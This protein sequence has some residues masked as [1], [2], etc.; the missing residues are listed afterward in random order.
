MT[1]RHRIMRR[2]RVYGS[3]LFDPTALTRPDEPAALQA[4]LD[5]QDDGG[6]RGLHFL[7]VNTSIKSQF[8]FIQQAWANNPSFGGLTDNPDPLIGDN[9]PLKAPGGMLI[10]GARSTIRTASL[11][12]FVTVRGGAYLFMPGLRTLRYL[13]EPH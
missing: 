4:I 11:P 2:G 9:D 10:P 1:S 3:P 8:E 12:R 5:I 13:A 7:C 6:S